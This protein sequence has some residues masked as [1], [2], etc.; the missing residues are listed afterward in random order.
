MPGSTAG[1]VEA[2]VEECIRKLRLQD[3][4]Q[5]EKDGPVVQFRARVR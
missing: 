4:W 5:A 1:D 3:R 2:E